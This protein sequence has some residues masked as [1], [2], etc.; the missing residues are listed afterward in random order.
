MLPAD[1]II[2]ETQR[3]HQILNLNIRKKI[4]KKVIFRDGQSDCS[5]GVVF[6][7]KSS[8]AKLKLMYIKS[9]SF[10]ALNFTYKYFFITGLFINGHSFLMDILF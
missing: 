1:G 5:F 10:S 4:T 9:T 6:V 3:D 8:A 2:M 7:V